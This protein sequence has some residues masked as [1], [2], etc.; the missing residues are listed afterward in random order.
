MREGLAP[1]LEFPVVWL[2]LVADVLHLTEGGGTSQNR[3]RYLVGVDTKNPAT[4]IADHVA[5][6]LRPPRHVATFKR[7]QHC[8]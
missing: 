6:G 4:G 8:V 2:Y 5:L 1:E 7:T 3:L